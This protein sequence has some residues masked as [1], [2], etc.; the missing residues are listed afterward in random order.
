[1]V[2]SALA[3]A[4]L[5]LLHGARAKCHMTESMGCFIDSSHARVL[6]GA[7]HLGVEGD[8][9]DLDHCAQLCHDKKFALAGV[10]DG[11]QCF[12]GNT[13]DATRPDNGCSTPCPSNSSEKC[14]GSDRIE[15]Y[16]FACIGPP[17]PALPPAPKPTPPPSPAHESPNLCPDFS[18]EYCK[19]SVPME[20]RIEMVLGYMSTEDKM[21]TMGEQGITGKYKDGTDLVARQVSWWNEALHG[22]CC[23]HC[24]DHCGEDGKKCPTQFPEAN[25]MSTS[26]NATLWRII[27]DTIS[28][29]G[30]AFYNVGGLNGM[31]YF[32]P[33]LNMAS[34]PL[35]GRNM[36]CDRLHTSALC[37]SSTAAL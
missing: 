6:T 9:M 29:E 34:N 11:H 16:K 15:I 19:P 20:E 31:T 8:G 1:M 4:L 5:G 13:I 26:F 10:E 37:S 36:E 7:T 24:Y 17:S 27:G 22:I 30:R 28:T 21:M 3:L 14:G 12:C 2:S 23:R 18:R 33:Q 35:W 25:A 32:A